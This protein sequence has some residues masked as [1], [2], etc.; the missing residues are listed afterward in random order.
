MIRA[1]AALVLVAL[2]LAGGWFAW[3]WYGPGPAE[4]DSSFIVRSGSTLTSVAGQLEEEGLIAN[5]EAFWKG[6]RAV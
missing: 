4:E 6:V 3:G 5:Q 1:L 2:A